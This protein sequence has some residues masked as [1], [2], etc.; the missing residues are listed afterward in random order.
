MTTR[1]TNLEGFRAYLVN[2]GRSPLTIRSYLA[3]M[4]QFG[5]FCRKPGKEVQRRDLDAYVARMLARDMSPKTIP[6]RVASLSAAP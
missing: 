2:R 5:R 6:P 3:D 1:P 4:G